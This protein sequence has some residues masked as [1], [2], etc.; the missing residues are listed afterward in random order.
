MNAVCVERKERRRGRKCSSRT[1]LRRVWGFPARNL[2]LQ[3]FPGITHAGW[4]QTELNAKRRPQKCAQGAKKRGRSEEPF[5]FLRLWGC[6]CS[7]HVPN[8]RFRS[9]VG[10]YTDDLSVI[11]AQ[12]VA[13][14]HQRHQL[15]RFRWLEAHTAEL[16][17]IIAWGRGNH[18][19]RRRRIRRRA[20]AHRG[21]LVTRAGA[22]ST[23][24]C[25]TS[26]SFVGRVGCKSCESRALFAA[27][28]ADRT[29]RGG[30]GH[31]RLHQGHFDGMPTTSSA[32]RST[33]RF[34]RLHVGEKASRGGGSKKSFFNRSSTK[35]GQTVSVF[36]LIAPVAPR[37]RCSCF[38]DTENYCH[39]QPT[40]WLGT[41]GSYTTNQNFPLFSFFYSGLDN[42]SHS[43]SPRILSGQLLP[44]NGL[45]NLSRDTTRGHDLRWQVGLGDLLAT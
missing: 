8:E 34:S 6:P 3:A 2:N 44:H 24:R 1:G 22:V 33:K 13:A 5:G 15:T 19:H 40:G 43:R 30:R 20:G 39:T 10:T 12:D 14:A 37:L 35:K 25:P 16:L 17:V 28:R 42:G 41:S 18:E 32:V 45:E 21:R 9:T 38:F 31:S 23:Y 7:R 36:S 27:Y 26:R 29:W 11:K 4:Y